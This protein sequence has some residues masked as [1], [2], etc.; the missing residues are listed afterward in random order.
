MW[1]RDTC[2]YILTKTDV[3]LDYMISYTILQFNKIDQ[4]THQKKKESKEWKNINV[5]YERNNSYKNKMT[6]ERVD[7]T[8]QSEIENHLTHQCWQQV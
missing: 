4:K 3:R 2:I 7:S 1:Y 8:R 6:G 5:L